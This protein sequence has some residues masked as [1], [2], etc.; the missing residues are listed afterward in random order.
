MKKLHYLFFSTL[1]ISCTAFAYELATHGAMTERAYEASILTTDASL[2]QQLGINVYTQN[3]STATNPF[4]NIYYDVSGA[5]IKERSANNFEN[6]IIE[7][8]LGTFGIQPLSL[9]GWL[10][11]GAIRED[12]NNTKYAPD[13]PDLP[14]VFHR[15]FNHFFD[16]VNNQPLTIFGA[17]TYYFLH[18]ANTTT[19][20]KAPDWAMGTEDVFTNANQ[21]GGDT[22]NHYTVLDAREAEYRALTLKAK[23]PDGSYTDIEPSGSLTTKEA[24]RKAYWATTFRA[25]GDILHLNQ[26]MAQPQHTR[27]EPHSGAGPWLAQALV[28]GHTSIYEKYIDARATGATSFD[29]DGST[30]SITGLTYTGYAIP[31]FNKY[32]DY[33]STSPGAGSFS[34]L[35]LA[36]YSNRG[37]FT[38]AHNI[39]DNTYTSPPNNPNSSFYTPVPTTYPYGASS[40]VIVNFLQGGVTDTLTNSSSAIKLTTQSVLNSIGSGGAGPVYSLN[41]FNYDDAASLLIPRATAYSAGLLNY[42]FRGRMQISLPGEGVYGIVDHAVNNLPDGQSGQGFA[43]IKLQIRNITPAITPPGGAAQAQDM[44]GGRLVAVAK[45]HRNLCY[46]PD[47]SG[48]YNLNGATAQSTCRD[49]EEKTLTS[50]AVL[51]A[52]NQPVTSVNLPAGGAPQTFSFV[53]NPPIPMNMTDFYL[54]VVYRGPL[55]T[56]NDAV[57]VATKDVAEPTFWS[58][59]NSTDYLYCVNGTFYYKDSSGNIPPG[60]PGYGNSQLNT[61]T[62]GVGQIVFQPNTLSTPLVDIIP[63]AGMA[64]GHYARLAVL[65]ET[66]QIYQWYFRGFITYPPQT[67]FTAINEFN[68][69]TGLYTNAP[70]QVFRRAYHHV[71]VTPYLYVQTGADCQQSG[72]PA[73][74]GSP[75]EPG[76]SYTAI[77]DPVYQIHGGFADPYASAGADQTVAQANT[78]TLSGGGA[79]SGNTITTYT[80]TQ[81]AGPT[82]SLSNGNTATPTFTA[83]TV[84]SDTVLSFQLAATDSSGATATSTV[85]VTVKA[86]PAPPTGTGLSLV[87]GNGR[88]TIGWSPVTGASSY[89]LYW[90][91]S[92]GVSPA[93]GTKI[94]NVT[95]AYTQTGLAN[96]TSY[97]YV[98]TAVNAVGEES[99][100]STQIAGTPAPAN[101]DLNGDGVVDAADVA[102]AERMALGLTTPSANQLAH[103]DINGDGVIDTADVEHIRRKA[104]G[105]ESF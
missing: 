68:P 88:N 25:L 64:P 37:F 15:E 100:A 27:N 94:T 65:T 35:G 39:D 53:F 81:T 62:I 70:T 97:Y 30:Q 87:A 42:F 74:G 59:Y 77:E 49:S 8:D 101:G 44:V 63:P 79:D 28:S 58:A 32:S 14:S 71:G 105:L 60:Q 75:P 76:Y 84:T 72:D 23:N 102:L 82:V 22:L 96:G 55:G 48:E 19:L 67:F 7:R 16:P 86:A 56:E 61:V 57:A 46:T 34:G 99:I 47:L 51:D 1:F 31:T 92:S 26:D 9:P 80:W 104:L 69:V 17:G 40:S 13:D 41:K 24:V 11:R 73:N 85:N 29:I 3:P 78:V 45:Y 5:Q 43:K 6:K 90:S 98:V 18:G 2:L 12:D 52:N 66:G 20:R 33:W 83:P 54:Q 50:T 103:G 91:T 89:N 10:L 93:T 36:D 21:R 4:G 38:A 95:S